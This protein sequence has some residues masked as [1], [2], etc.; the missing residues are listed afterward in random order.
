MLHIETLLFL[1]W[2]VEK[3]SSGCHMSVGEARGEL[4][5]PVLRSSFYVWAWDVDLMA[6]RRGGVVLD[7]SSAVYPRALIYHGSRSFTLSCV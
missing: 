7:A 3:W 1:L 4:E 2:N 6:S 5:H